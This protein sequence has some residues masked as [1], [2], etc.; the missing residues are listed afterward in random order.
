MRRELRGVTYSERKSNF[1]PSLY[2]YTLAVCPGGG[3]LAY[4]IA[5]SGPGRPRRGVGCGRGLAGGAARSAAHAQPQVTRVTLSLIES[6]TARAHKTTHHVPCATPRLQ[7]RAHHKASF[8]I[9]ALSM[10][11]TPL[12][13]SLVASP[14]TRHQ[15]SSL[16]MRIS[17]S[18]VAQ[19]SCQSRSATSRALPP[20]RPTPH[21]TLAPRHTLTPHH[22]RFTMPCLQASRATHGAVSVHPIK[23]P[24]RCFDHEA[25]PHSRPPGSCCCGSPCGKRRGCP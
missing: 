3:S 16:R 7:Y 1:S 20:L 19:A 4:S 25:R 11:P 15:P 14:C 12:H 21:A 22:S 24:T 9:T 10:R 17:A 18:H 23:T 8:L 6:L 5:H 13:V 2:E